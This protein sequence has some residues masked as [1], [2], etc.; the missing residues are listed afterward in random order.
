MG[1][2]LS[3]N[4]PVTHPILMV[5]RILIEPLTGFLRQGMTPKELA[6]TIALGFTLGLTPVLG[7]TTILCTLAALLLRLNL[8][9]IQLINGLTYPL[10]LALFIPFLRA[11]AWVFRT[12]DPSLTLTQ[13]AALIRANVWHAIAALWVVTMHALLVWLLFGC[14]ATGV[15]YLIL[16]PILE[17]WS[18]IE[19][20]RT[21][22][23]PTP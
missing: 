10:Q 4:A 5:R 16:V 3:L 9:A 19:G 23:T 17:K 15:L 12:S 20:R 18:F 8:P 21:A 1:T 14:V 13:I 22:T 6:L 7:S 2:T 11:G